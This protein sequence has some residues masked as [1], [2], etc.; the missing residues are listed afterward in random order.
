MA[1]D[2]DAAQYIPDDMDDYLGDVDPDAYLAVE[3]EMYELE[4]EGE[5]SGPAPPAPAPPV[6]SGAGQS[7]PRRL[8]FAAYG[9]LSGTFSDPMQPPASQVGTAPLSSQLQLRVGTSSQAVPSAAAASG[10]AGLSHFQRER[11]AEE[12]RAQQQ[13]QQ[14]SSSMAR[15]PSAVVPPP[16]LRSVS[17][18][19]QRVLEDERVYVFRRAPAV[20]EFMSVTSASGNRVYLTKS[21]SADFEKKVAAHRRAHRTQ[22]MHRDLGQV[23]VRRMLRELDQEAM[24]A[25]VKASA[26]EAK[27]RELESDPEDD[28]RT[29]LRKR[30]QRKERLIARLDKEE[31][32][33]KLAGQ[34]SKLWVDKYS[35]RGYADLLSPEAINREVLE[36]LRGW[37]LCV[38][39]AKK[40]AA[41]AAT[42]ADA[43]R[44]LDNHLL[45]NNLLGPA[46]AQK[47][48]KKVASAGTVLG[49]ADGETDIRPEHKIILL[50]G[51]PG[52]GKSTLAHVLARQAGYHPYEINASDDRSGAALEQKIRA[53]TEMQSVSFGAAHTARPNC[54]ILD[55]IDGV[56]GETSGSQDA[57]GTILKIVQAEPKSKAK[58]GKKDDAATG[59]GGDESDS[60]GGEDDKS[61]NNASSSA[62]KSKSGSGAASSKPA[63]LKRPI[64]CICNDQFAAALRPLR[65]VARVFEFHAAPKLKFVDRLKFVARNEGMDVD[66]RTLGALADL[67]DC[68][69]RSAL[70]TLQFV[71]SRGSKLTASVLNSLSLGR[72]DVEKSRL[73]VWEAVFSDREQKKDALLHFKDMRETEQAGRN[74]GAGAGNNS[75]GSSN[76]ASASAAVSAP[77]TAKE[78][79]SRE[80]A[81]LLADSGD[82]DKVLEG[83]FHNYPTVGYTDPSMHKTGECADWLCFADLLEKRS[84]VSPDDSSMHGY[85]PYAALGIHFLTSRPR[86]VKLEFPTMY[87]HQ[88]V[89]EMRNQ[90]IVRSFLSPHNCFTLQGATLHSTVLD[91][92]PHVLDILHPSIRAVNF[93]LLTTKEK[94]ELHN[95]VDSMLSM[96]ITYR[97]EII[98]AFGSSNAAVPAWKQSIAGGGGDVSN[99]VYKLDP[100][101][102]LLGQWSNPLDAAT[103]RRFEPANKYSQQR[104]LPFG[105]PQQPTIQQSFIIDK[106]DVN[107]PNKVKR[108]VLREVSETKLNST[109]LDCCLRNACSCC[110]FYFF[111]LFVGVDV[112]CSVGVRIYASR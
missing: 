4:Q 1:D 65:Q 69:I 91:V 88:Y 111:C 41:Q 54:V 83:V 82:L 42:G 104:K 39:G 13:H 103:A 10:S 66:S 16:M 110:S 33:L 76:G 36:W 108:E 38:F 9:D 84:M 35:P 15:A 99:V 92:L 107:M 95:L 94:A 50:C 51:P 73:T 8:D 6:P 3:Q 57:I 55:E 32:E 89:A 5:S 60:D 40:G 102:E 109:W 64:I 90:Q 79:K 28:E 49:G 77:L 97:A 68:D 30:R 98:Q 71:H 62:R 44:T 86:K 81:G 87:Y 53:A 25:S 75:N 29:K 80:L 37:D 85:V 34:N 78:A 27:A 31:R 12:Q 70:N 21:S 26:A 61:D 22:Q 52:L 17:E 67:T 14:P 105:A 20:G 101:I 63:P 23:N 96:A 100:S 72:K 56:Q 24:A 43:T 112:G 18:L 7:N 58:G 46:S 2:D 48:G 59:G 11:M 19:R 45:T 47:K 74:Q 93:A 106:R